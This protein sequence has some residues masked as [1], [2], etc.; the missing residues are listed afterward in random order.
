MVIR[1][2]DQV[3]LFLLLLQSPCVPPPPPHFLYFFSPPPAYLSPAFPCKLLALKTLLPHP[4]PQREL[5]LVLDLIICII[6][7]VERRLCELVTGNEF[8]YIERSL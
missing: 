4:P 5:R 2:A 6:T 1:V 8:R 7:S 3:P